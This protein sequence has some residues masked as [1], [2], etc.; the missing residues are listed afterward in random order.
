MS[1]TDTHIGVPIQDTPITFTS[2]KMEAI[3]NS[4]ISRNSWIQNRRQQTDF[5]HSP[6]THHK[7]QQ[8]QQH[9]CGYSSAIGLRYPVSVWST[10]LLW[11][12]QSRKEWIIVLPYFKN[13]EEKDKR[14]FYPFLHFLFA[15]SEWNTKHCIF[16]RRL[17]VLW[18]QE[19]L[20]GLTKTPNWPT[21]PGKSSPVSNIKRWPILKRW[22]KWKI[23]NKTT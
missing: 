6:Q 13:S 2:F 21:D 20:G 19:S 1:R 7:K 4:R 10:V 9:A 15:L 5:L 14:E 23:M 16:F 22:V 17:L 8:Q 12:S 11:P 18:P 3:L